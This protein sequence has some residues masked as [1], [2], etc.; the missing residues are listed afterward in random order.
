MGV[1]QEASGTAMS[2]ASTTVPI[3][4]VLLSSASVAG[5]Q[6]WRDASLV[7]R[8]PF[9]WGKDR[10]SNYFHKA[11][12][13]RFYLFDQFPS[14]FSMLQDVDRFFLLLRE[15]KGN[16]N[17]VLKTG[18]AVR[19][20]AAWRAAAESACSG[21]MV[22]VCAVLRLGLE[23]A[24]C[25]HK[26][27]VDKTSEHIFLNRHESP[28]DN[29]ASRGIFAASKLIDDVSATDKELCDRLKF[30]YNILID[31]GAHPNERSFS[32]GAILL[33][34]EARKSIKLII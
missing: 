26:V 10:L 7:I 19:S 6:L 21:Q 31:F 14:L 9:A 1:L 29:K 32:A 30:T 2:Y 3:L 5:S 12:G 23:Y 17:D 34:R 15:K 20:H 18:L 28:E 13:N 25:A 22:A 11:H 33:P 24:L 27:A 16:V 8:P 4:W